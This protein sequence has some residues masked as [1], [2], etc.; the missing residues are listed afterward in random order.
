MITLAFTRPIRRLDESVELAKSYGFDVVAGPSLDIVHSPKAD[1]DGI[2]DEL[3]KGRISTAIFSSATAAEECHAEWGDDMKVL[4]E[5]TEVI[6]IGPGTSRRLEAIGIE[7]SSIP[8][9]YTSSGLVEHLN[10]NTDGRCVLVIHSDKGSS[11]LMDGLR[12]AGFRAEELIAYT[13]EKHTGG[14]DRIREAAEDDRVDVYAFTSRMSAESFLDDIGIAK[15]KL[16][17]RAKVAAIGQPTKER[18]EEEGVKV[19]IIPENATFPDL[20]QTIKEQFEK[21]GSE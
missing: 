9:E 6:A 12:E 13:L 18:L 5:D 15:D 16:F 21:E 8:K 19:D 2:R 4:F 17:K 1:Y 3:K 10:A 11:I 7:V 14:L 20:L